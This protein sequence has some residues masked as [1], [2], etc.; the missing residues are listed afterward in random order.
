MS[1]RGF[2]LPGS[3]RKR[4]N[5]W[6]GAR[7]VVSENTRQTGSWGSVRGQACCLQEPPGPSRRPLC[8]RGRPSAL[9][10][11]QLCCRS[12]PH[13]LPGSLGG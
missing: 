7:T 10:G 3:V 12:P 5:C 2:L 6:C 11:P 9:G 13:G 8:R 4:M 1:S